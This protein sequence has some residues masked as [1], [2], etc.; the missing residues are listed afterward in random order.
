MELDE[1]VAPER[2]DIKDMN[3]GIE[4]DA[5]FPFLQIE[6][7]SLF[8]KQCVSY[9]ITAFLFVVP[10]KMTYLPHCILNLN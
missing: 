1:T 2:T 4:L 9:T 3:I 6:N 5:I 8:T 10:L 7:T